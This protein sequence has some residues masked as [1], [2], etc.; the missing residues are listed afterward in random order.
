MEPLPGN[1]AGV[2]RGKG[3]APGLQEERCHQVKNREKASRSRFCW[4][5]GRVRRIGPQRS[6]SQG[7]RRSTIPDKGEENMETNTM[8]ERPP[9]VTF[10]LNMLFLSLGIGIIR[11]LYVWFLSGAP[12]LIGSALVTH[13]ISQIIFH[14]RAPMWVVHGDLL[15]VPI[16]VWLYYMIGKGKNW[17]R[18]SLLIFIVLETLACLMTVAS[19]V[20]L[21]RFG[22]WPVSL[23]AL[24]LSF[25]YYVLQAVP[26]IVGVIPLF[27]RVSSEWFKAMKVRN[28]QA[29][30]TAN[31]VIIRLAVGLLVLLTVGVVF[32]QVAYVSQ[33]EAL[34][35]A[36]RKKDV[37]QVQ[38]LLEKGADINTKD[39][40]GFPVLVSAAAWGRVEVVKL[41]LDYGVNVDTE[42][43]GGQTALM[44][45]S[46]EDQLDVVRLLLNN[47]AK[48]N[49][50][51]NDGTTA[52]MKASWTGAHN[53][54]KLLLDRGAEINAKD[55][56]GR[57]ALMSASIRNHL[58]IVKLLLDRG[59]DINA[60]NGV[61]A[62]A[63]MKALTISPELV[64]L[65]VDEGSDVNAKDE[66]G[67]TALLEASERGNRDAVRLLLEKEAD[68]SVK[69]VSGATALSLA[70]KRGHG[71]IVELLKAHGATE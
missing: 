61:G 34:I 3:T 58:D 8:L 40:F 46:W 35:Q 22:H 45:A 18:I 21:S 14:F 47:G 66:Q 10:A 54:V 25:G 30:T 28:R 51:D 20:T 23:S 38:E 43:R 49:A 39:R 56:G 55:S 36:I 12:G 68:V 17:A 67:V 64:K 16:A 33:R 32:Y 60:K 52:L 53:V 41:L 62:T 42:T 1:I 44:K 13:I 57:T 29:R 48:I 5:R 59:A 50:K 70:S 69:T 31:V 19:A 63:L 7:L 65:L 6:D 26:A 2:M 24:L 15:I 37:R 71:Q 11:V 4:G 27:G 9:T